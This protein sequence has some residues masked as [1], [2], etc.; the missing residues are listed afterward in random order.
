MTTQDLAMVVIAISA[1]VVA[2]AFVIVAVSVRGL[3]ADA[4]DVARH[5]QA[6]IAVLERDLPPTIQQARE[7]GAGISAV[8][9][10]AQPRL[11]RVDSLLVEA[12]ATLIAVREV[13]NSL[14]GLVGG[15]AA[16]V[17]SVKR[18]VT[19]MAGGVVAA[20]DRIRRAITRDDDDGEADR[21][22]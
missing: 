19:T 8:T 3:S 20:G 13:S 14:N 4:R 10:E 21:E 15:P 17:S 12:E 6:L 16:T 5:S 2:V 9:T 22:G 7:L 11:E 18:S 1:A